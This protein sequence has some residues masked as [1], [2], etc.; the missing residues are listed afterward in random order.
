MTLELLQ[1]LTIE[2]SNL[3]MMENLDDVRHDSEILN[4]LRGTVP[5]ISIVIKFIIYIKRK[6]TLAI[7]CSNL[8][9]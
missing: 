9:T 8:S 5:A 2:C 3:S 6:L 4:V 7:I 1:P